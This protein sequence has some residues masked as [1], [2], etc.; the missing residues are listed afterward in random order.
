[1]V[2]R[3][4]IECAKQGVV[5][6]LVEE[7]RCVFFFCKSKG[8]EGN[9]PGEVRTQILYRKKQMGKKDLQGRNKSFG[10]WVSKYFS[11]DVRDA[12]RGR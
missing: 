3:Y 4:E 2:L 6:Q 12:S 9:K 7:I 11:H 1:M 8:H 5:V 10:I